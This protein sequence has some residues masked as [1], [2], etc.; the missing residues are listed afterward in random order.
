MCVSEN[1]GILFG[2]PFK[3]I[4]FSLWYKR[5]ALF[6]E[7]PILGSELPGVFG[8]FEGLNIF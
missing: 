1:R 4:L 2:C 3:G 6:W 5:G 7:I 8:V